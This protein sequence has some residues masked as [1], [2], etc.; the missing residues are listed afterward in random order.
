M[1]PWLAK[2][3]RKDEMETWDAITA[4]SNVREYKPE[5]RSRYA[6]QVDRNTSA[7]TLARPAR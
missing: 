2:G 1:A 5:L 7:V 6:V 4:R 3:R